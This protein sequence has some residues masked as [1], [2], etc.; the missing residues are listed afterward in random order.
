MSIPETIRFDNTGEPLPEGGGRELVRRLFLALV[1]ALVAGAS[2]GVGRLTGGGAGEPV[3]I[4]FDPNL[5]N[6]V[7]AVRPAPLE[8]GPSGIAGSQGVVASKSGSKYHY[9]S[10]PGAKQIKEENRI[11]F[12]TAEEAE[13]AGYSLA[14]N[15]K[16]P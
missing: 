14:S 16:G 3:R 11:A 4:E 8:A 5:A 15:C 13:A 7:Q 12:K 9:L 1:I 6:A 2:F 10:C